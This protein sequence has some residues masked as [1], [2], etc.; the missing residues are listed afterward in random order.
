MPI[1]DNSGTRGKD[2]K[3]ETK[4][5]SIHHLPML[6]VGERRIGPFRRQLFFPDEV[7]KEGLVAKLEAGLLKLKVPKHGHK[8]IPTIANIEVEPS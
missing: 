7:D 4:N 2:V 3:W 1:T 8:I 6:L 5:P